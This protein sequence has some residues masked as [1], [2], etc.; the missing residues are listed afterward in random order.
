[1]DRR[2][3]LLLAVLA[4]VVAGLLPLAA[5]LYESFVLDGR[6]TLAIY[7]RLFAHPGRHATSIGHSLQLA[8]LTAGCATL[9]GAPLGVLL[10]KTDLSLRR[11]LLVVLSVPL[12]LPPYII[13]VCWFDLFAPSGLLARVAPAQT[14]E[15]LSGGL[16]G[17]PGCLGVLAS[18]FMPVTMILTFAYLRTVSPRLEEAGRLIASWPAVLRTI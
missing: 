6:P 1:M 10:G 8:A 14:L 3:A 18:A 15:T 13:A 5:M 12:L 7:A 9:L 17:L 11:L 16:F 4:L 2:L